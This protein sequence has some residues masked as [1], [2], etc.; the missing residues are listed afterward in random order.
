MVNYGVSR[1]CEECKRR[2]KKK[3]CSK[4]G[5]SCSGYKDEATLVF[6]HWSNQQASYALPT[7][8]WSPET[9]DKKL[10]EL[11]LRIFNS[12][13][14]VET[15]DQRP[16]RGFL[17]GIQILLM[18][19]DSTSVLA[20]SAKILVLAS[21]GN[22]LGRKSLL[23]KTDRD[24]GNLLR[25]FHQS[26]SADMKYVS[27]ES[28][29]TA[30][31]LGLYEIIVSHSTSPMQY[32]AHVRGVCAI[33]SSPG[34]PFQLATGGRTLQ[35][36][37]PLNF[38]NPLQNDV[39]VYSPSNDMRIRR[40]DATLLKFHNFH[41]RAGMHLMQKFPTA[42]ENLKLESI[43]GSDPIYSRMTIASFDEATPELSGC[44]YSHS[45]PVDKYSDYFI[46]AVWNT[47]CKSQVMLLDTMAHLVG[48]MS[49]EDAI[50][51]FKQRAEKMI[52]EIIASIPYHLAHNIND[53]LNCIQSR[54]TAIP[55]NGAFS[56]LLLLYPLFES[57]KC[58]IV[59]YKDRLY[60]A[61]C[62]LWIGEHMGIGQAS[63]LGNCVN[64][65]MSEP[66][67]LHDPQFP[68]Q[69]V[70]EGNLLIW[71]SMAL[72][73]KSLDVLPEKNTS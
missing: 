63:L 37:N 33:L 28:L 10:E 24:Y 25:K 68:F 8:W 31:L 32:M 9:D 16:S 21:I 1:G 36:S 20:C 72:Q 23:I 45:G 66:H 40:L 57:S 46:A 70:S 47:H 14:V 2:R 52:M 48:R 54:T 73:P 60:L 44:T 7:L 53:Y 69:E 19:I 56:G 49:G 71:A 12:E 17:D 58:K 42:E 4:T 18:T 30:I 55:S 29:F 43:N 15:V 38:N 26:L 13:F 64:R 41:Q 50:L 39:V 34:S 67:P 11:S 27:V 59:P 5:K 61:R 51:Q 35:L 22:R 65:R 3:R 62:L 6:R